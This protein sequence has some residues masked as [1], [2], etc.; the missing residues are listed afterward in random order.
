MLQ[1]LVNNNTATAFII[2]I[3]VNNIFIIRLLL[4]WPMFIAIFI[5]KPLKSSPKNRKKPITNKQFWDKA[6]KCP[7]ISDKKPLI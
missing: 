2:E 6:K 1:N 7:T 5:L 4:F 3:P